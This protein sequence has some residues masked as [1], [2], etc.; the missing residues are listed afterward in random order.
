MSGLSALERARIQFGFTISFHI[1]FPAITIGLAGFLTVLELRWL[2]TGKAVY[3]DLYHYWIKIF[4]VNFG[5][6]VV[7]DLVMAIMKTEGDLQRP[8]LQLARLVVL[9]ISR[10]GEAWRWI[11]MICAILF[12]PARPPQRQAGGGNGGKRIGW[13]VLIWALSAIALGLV[14]GAM[15]SF[16]HALGM[17]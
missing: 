11:P 8:M 1:I 17:H 13:L 4:S 12:N 15:R 2:Q 7:S 6:G 5:M 10:Q 9:R 16:M 14:A 3:L